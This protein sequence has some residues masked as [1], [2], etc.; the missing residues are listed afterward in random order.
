MK[1]ENPSGALIDFFYSA[2]STL[3]VPLKY[4]TELRRFVPHSFKFEHFKRA[5]QENKWTPQQNST[6][7]KILIR[8]NRM[9]RENL[10][11]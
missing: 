10:N 5:H 9:K 1:S 3:A 7:R 11:K 6:K 4:I 2:A 8:H